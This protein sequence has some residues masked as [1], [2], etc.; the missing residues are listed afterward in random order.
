MFRAGLSIVQKGYLDDESDIIRAMRRLL[1][2]LCI[3][4][5]TAAAAQSRASAADEAAVRDIVRRYTQARELNDPKAIEALF[6]ES[7]DRYTTSGDWRRGVQ[8]L[9]K[10]MLETSAINPGKRAINIAA[11]Q[12]CDPG[13]RDR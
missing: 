3:A 6:T 10:G 12:I 2:L 7:A 5:A 8:A 11:V 4:T 9:V 13:R 1:V